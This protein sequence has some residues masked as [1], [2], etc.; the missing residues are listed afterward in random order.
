MPAISD[1]EIIVADDTG[2][3]LRWIELEIVAYFVT[4]CVISTSR[5]LSKEKTT[6]SISDE[7]PLT[8]VLNI[9]IIR[10]S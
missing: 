6:D 7:P 10:L 9:T 5:S 8:D 3:L 2:K 4:D 1:G